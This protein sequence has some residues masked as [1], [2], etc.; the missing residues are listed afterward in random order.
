MKLAAG[1]LMA[2]LAGAESILND[3]ALRTGYAN[4][5]M[6]WK[7]ST[8]LKQKFESESFYFLFC[9]KGVKMS[10]YYISKRNILFSY[11]DAVGRFANFVS[12]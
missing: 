1:S 6:S 5:G 8:V 2:S 9:G 7:L 12:F 4:S 3:S 11:I 10:Q